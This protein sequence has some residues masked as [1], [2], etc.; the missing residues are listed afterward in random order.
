MDMLNMKKKSMFTSESFR[1]FYFEIM[2][3]CSYINWR[4]DEIER[5]GKLCREKH[6]QL[7]TLEAFSII[8]SDSGASS[9]K[10]PQGAKIV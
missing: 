6:I 5:I 7:S 3:A 9:L 8:V 1:N 2:H 10:F 4:L